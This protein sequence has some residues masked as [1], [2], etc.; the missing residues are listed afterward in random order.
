M[1]HGNLV[2]IGSHAVTHTPLPTLAWHMQREEI[3]HSKASLERLL[4]HPV[5]SFCYPYGAYAAETIGL[6]RDTG[7]VCACTTHPGTIGRHVDPL[8]LPRVHVEDW[9]GEEFAKRLSLWF[10]S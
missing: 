10:D 7:F 3:Q 4:G 6:V 8:Q 2:E 1:A 5:T 9:D